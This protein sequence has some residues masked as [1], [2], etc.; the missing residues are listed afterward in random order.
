MEKVIIT[1]AVTGDNLPM[2][3]P[4]LPLTPKQIADEAV[5]AAEA[6][7]A[8]VHIHAREPKQGRPSADIGIFREILTSIK[9]RSDVIINITSGGTVGQAPEERKQV[10]PAFKPELSSY[11]VGSLTFTLGGM[12]EK[13]KDEDYKY[14]WEKEFLQLWGREVW[15]NPYD[16][17]ISLGKMMQENGTK[18][19]YEIFDTGW[20]HNAHYIYRTKGGFTN[21]PLWLQ[22]VMGVGGGVPATMEHFLVLKRQADDLFGKE[23]YKWSVIGIGYPGQFNMAAL[24]LMN[25]GHVRV[26]LED[27]LKIGPDVLA[28]SN[29]ELVEKAVRLAREFDREV[30]SP[31]E[32]RK[33]LGLKGKDKVKF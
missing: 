32:T 28:K 18:P 25:G 12:V 1:A 5:R 13:I 11:D 15:V 20:L 6:G 3:S 31:D 33:I 2:Q 4:W 29:A 22:F 17:L 9:R 14:P 27:T 23:N 26:G 30:A 21:P 7:A 10:I 8:I 19:E 24:A 16:H